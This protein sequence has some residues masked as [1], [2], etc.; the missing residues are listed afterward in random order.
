M[1]VSTR[2]IKLM[3]V[4]IIYLINTFVHG[5]VFKT[6]THLSTFYV[7]TQCVIVPY[8]I[9]SCNIPNSILLLPYN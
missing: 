3:D 8:T 9:R 5:F 6:Y 4:L 1:Y 2:I 7:F